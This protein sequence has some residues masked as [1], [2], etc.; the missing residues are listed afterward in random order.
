NNNCERIHENRD[1]NKKNNLKEDTYKIN[2]INNN[3]DKEKRVS[4][5]N[6][7]KNQNKIDN[8]NNEKENKNTDISINVEI[9]DN[10]I[11]NDYTNKKAKENNNILMDNVNELKSIFEK[12]EKDIKLFINNKVKNN[13][14]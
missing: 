7:F 2:E 8:L 11:N 1:K 5:S 3:D 6:I 14:I 4:Y 13:N 10:S 9:N 12:N